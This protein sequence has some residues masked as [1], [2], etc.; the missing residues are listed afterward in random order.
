MAQ[1]EKSIE[2]EVPLST[3]YNQWTQFKEFP[4]FMEGVKEVKQLNDTTLHWKA[5]IGGK[6]VEWTAKILHQVPD[7]RV[8]WAS[9]EGAK[10]SG[11][12]GFQSLGP[13]KSRITLRIDYEPE[14]AIEKTGSALGVVSAR[15]EG[16]LKRFK[17][18]IEERGRETGAWRAEVHG[19]KVSGAE[20]GMSET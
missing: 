15:V 9:T 8:A 4:R 5:N 18:F 16:D 17:K 13:N 3:A 12:V 7:T 10:H 19:G 1:I 14:G 2:V 6:D 20:A 11:D